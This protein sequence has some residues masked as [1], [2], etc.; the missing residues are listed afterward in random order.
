MPSIGNLQILLHNIDFNCLCIQNWYSNLK[1]HFF[2]FKYPNFGQAAHLGYFWDILAAI[3]KGALYWKSLEFF[4]YASWYCLVLI[5]IHFT[6][7]FLKNSCQ[8]FSYLHVPRFWHIFIGKM[9]AI[10]DF[11]VKMNK[12]CQTNPWNEFLTMELVKID[13]SIAHFE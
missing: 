9:A 12:F 4:K 10:L 13:T 11:R 6:Y 5:K 7:F 2:S 3:L 8:Y 1:K